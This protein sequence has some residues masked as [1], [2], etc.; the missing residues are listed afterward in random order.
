MR[1]SPIRVL[2]ADDHPLMR[3]GIAAVVAAEADMLLVAEAEDGVDAIEQ[4]RKSSPDVVLMDVR[5]P[6]MDGIQATAAL[7]AGFPDTKVIVLTAHAGDLQARL[8]L[9]A[10]AS[11]YLLKSAVRGELVRTIRDLKDGGGVRRAGSFRQFG[12]V[13]DD[14]ILSM[15]EVE[16]LE[17]VAAG[18]ANAR[19][20]AHLSIAEE[21]VKSHLKSIFAKLGARDRTHAAVIGYRR[22]II[23]PPAWP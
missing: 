10:G 23:P 6:R 11:G 9:R 12:C 15:R 1:D 14:S 8:A 18:H 16:V 21:T 2:A 20:A 17:A 13:N 3:Q 4:C 19:V 22:G 5:M 7:R